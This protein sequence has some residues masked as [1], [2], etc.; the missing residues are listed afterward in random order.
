MRLLEERNDEI[1]ELKKVWEIDISEIVLT[2]RI[3]GDS[4]GAFGEVYM[5]RYASEAWATRRCSSLFVRLCY[6]IAME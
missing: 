6:I 3:D 2:R 5:A 1:T 4:P